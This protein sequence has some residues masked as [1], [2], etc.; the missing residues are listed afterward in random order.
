MNVAKAISLLGFSL[1]G[2]SAAIIIVPIFGTAG[3]LFQLIQVI[4]LLCRGLCGSS[5]IREEDDLSGYASPS[6]SP[7]YN[8][9]YYYQSNASNNFQSGSRSPNSTS[10][11]K[12]NLKNNFSLNEEIN[13][14]EVASDNNSGIEAAVAINKTQLNAL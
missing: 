10:K 13:A 9:P 4:I 14:D 3:I 2:L 12:I 5:N 8:S 6:K 11:F 7:P 1:L